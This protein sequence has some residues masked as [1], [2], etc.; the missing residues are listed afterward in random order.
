[1]SLDVVDQLLVAK[2]GQAFEVDS[3]GKGLPL[4]VEQVGRR[5]LF[6]GRV[7]LRQGLLANFAH[8]RVDL[9]LLAGRLRHVLAL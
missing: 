2:L 3:I 5:R 1:M 8:I 9:V 7:V 6:P 4:E